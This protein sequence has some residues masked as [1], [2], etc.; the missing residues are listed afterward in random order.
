MADYGIRV[1]DWFQCRIETPAGPVLMQPDVVAVEGDDV[2][3]QVGPT[4]AAIPA[5]DLYE[6]YE[7]SWEERGF[8]LVPSPNPGRRCIK[9]SM[10]A[11]AV[12]QPPPRYWA[13]VAADRAREFCEGS[14]EELGRLQPCGSRPPQFCG[15]RR[16][17]GDFQIVSFGEVRGSAAT[18]AGFV[19]AVQRYILNA[20]EP[21][22]VLDT[23]GIHPAQRRMDGLM[24]RPQGVN[25]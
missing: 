11:T 9:V 2:W 6:R 16:I 21:G 17:P 1:G 7:R 20:C 15:L 5:E 22:G 8:T 12:T 3:L 18:T 13:Q 14:L 25:T 10:T 23:W 19:E 24:G 4:I